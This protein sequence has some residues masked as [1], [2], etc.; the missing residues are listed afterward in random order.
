MLPRVGDTR[1]DGQPQSGLDGAAGSRL[2]IAISWPLPQHFLVSSVLLLCLLTGSENN[3]SLEAKGATHV[4][5]ASFMI[6][7]MR[8]Q[9]HRD[10]RLSKLIALLVGCSFYELPFIEYSL[11]IRSYTKY[12][13]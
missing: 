6:L 9:K 7:E 1:A 11:C 8:I 3:Q 4:M 5:W 2:P 10:K 13:T 12:L